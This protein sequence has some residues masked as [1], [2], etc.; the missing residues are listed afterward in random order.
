MN[1]PQFR[2]HDAELRTPLPV[3][4]EAEQALLGGLMMRPEVLG[5]VAGHLKAEHFFEPLHQA[6]YEVCLTMS[7]AGRAPSPITIKD[8]LPAD[9]H[10]ADFTIPQYLAKLLS[11][12]MPGNVKGFAD[13]II[14]LAVRRALVGIGEGIQSS[15]LDAPAGETPKHLIE[16][17]IERLSVLSATGMRRDQRQSTAGAAASIIVDELEAGTALSPPL[18]TGLDDLDSYIG[19][20]RRG[21]LQILA[22][23]PGMGKS[24][25][26][27]S[28]ALNVAKEGDG[29]LFFSMEMTKDQ[30]VARMLADLCY[31]TTL[32]ILYQH[33]TDRKIE[34]ADRSEIAR[35]AEFLRSLPL[36]IDPQ[37]NMTMME[38]ATRARRVA[39]SMERKGIRLGLIAIDHLGKVREAGNGRDNRTIELGAM[40]NAAANLAKDVDACCLMLCQ[41]NRAVESRDNKRPQL[42]DL[43]ESGRIEEDAD[44]VI[45]LYREAYYL[46]QKNEEDPEKEIALKEKLLER[47]FD[48]EAIILKNRHGRTGTAKLFAH[49]GAGAVRNRDRRAYGIAA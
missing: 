11:D 33:I 14:D 9:L 8:Y 34:P 46:E 40:T 22:G 42:S 30:L 24:L 47:G 28:T 21:N 17:A 6:I 23:R 41:L 1:A 13:A 38:I 15:A 4:L 49:V 31:R 10:V 3:N 7:A 2:A 43:R 37:P 27:G 48:L 5:T 25:L 45:A 39:E 44:S 12:A 26:A 36:I 29:V 35:A 18:S 19:G 16:D 20:F 32:P